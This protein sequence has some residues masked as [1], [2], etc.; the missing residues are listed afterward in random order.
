[1]PEYPKEPCETCGELITTHL[2]GRANHMKK[3]RR[4]H[5]AKA[6]GTTPEAEPVAGVVV[7]EPAVLAVD[8]PKEPLFSLEGLNPKQVQEMQAALAADKR[9]RAEAP[10][11]MMRM[12][13]PDY[14][15]RIA[16][17][18]KD[19][20]L[21]PDGY[22]GAWGDVEKHKLHIAN[23]RI[24]IHEDGHRVQHGDVELHAVADVVTKA[25]QLASAR[26]SHERFWGERE[27]GD[28]AMKELPAE[29]RS[30]L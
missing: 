27:K 4:E 23:G 3:C 14:L 6:L 26:L 15:K 10:D 17:R 25:R 11:V 8:S 29:V 9:L 28:A 1:M 12:A 7:T 18:C 13:V 24:P 5:E 16:K 19:A 21:I 30:A 22:D 2:G 20:G